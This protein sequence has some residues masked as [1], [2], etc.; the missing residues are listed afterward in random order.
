MAEYKGHNLAVVFNTVDISGQARSVTVNEEAGEPEQ[1]DVTHKGDSERQLLEGF[2]GAQR[3]SVEMNILDD[4]DGDSALLEFA[5]NA[6]DTLFVYP[7]GQTHTYQ[8]IVIQ[9]A[10]LI[11][12]AEPIV[13]DQAVEITVNFLALNNCTRGTYSSA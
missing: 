13:Y 2:A 1:L 3:T 4:D 7:E 8:E 12:R 9:N 10:R 5:V 6:K 11:S